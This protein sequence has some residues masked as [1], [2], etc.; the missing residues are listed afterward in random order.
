MALLMYSLIRRHMKQTERF[1]VCSAEQPLPFSLDV[2]SERVVGWYDN[3]E[4]W[5]GRR[6]VFTDGAIYVVDEAALMRIG[7]D[8]MTEYELPASKTEST[9]VRIRTK[10]GFRFVRIA[11]RSGPDG[12]FSDAFTLVQL[13][14][15][16]L[17]AVRN[18]AK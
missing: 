8:E 18:K 9:G 2:G 10:D 6:V 1:T 5:K 11:G 15:A 3:P 17:G 13:V 12:K 7:F 16:F 14:R 4:P